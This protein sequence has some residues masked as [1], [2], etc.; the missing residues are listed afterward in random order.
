MAR[1][2]VIKDK[3][4]ARKG[5]YVDGDSVLAGD[6][7]VTGDVTFD[8]GI[9]VGA[10]IDVATIGPHAS[11]V[12][13]TQ[14]HSGVEYQVTGP[15][16]IGTSLSVGG[17]Y[18]GVPTG[19]TATRV[20]SEFSWVPD[21]SI[22]YNT[23][24]DQLEIVTDGQWK[25]VGVLNLLG[26]NDTPT[27]YT[28]AGGLYAQV[29][30]E[31][32]GLVFSA[33]EVDETERR[34]L[35]STATKKTRHV[36]C[37]GVT[38]QDT[39]LHVVSH[40]KLTDNVI[41][42]DDGS[43]INLWEYFE[44]G[45][46]SFVSSPDGSE[47][48]SSTGSAGTGYAR[49]KN[50]LSVEPGKSYYVTAESRN[51]ED[52]K[53]LVCDHPYAANSAA[54]YSGT[55]YAKVYYFDIPMLDE[56]G[57]TGGHAFDTTWTTGD[58]ENGQITGVFTAMTDK[59]FF[60]FRHGGISSSSYLDNIKVREIELPK[61]PLVGRQMGSAQT[62]T[63]G[64]VQITDGNWNVINTDTYTIS[65]WLKTPTDSGLQTIFSQQGDYDNLTNTRRPIYFR[66]DGSN[67]DFNGNGQTVTADITDNNWH[68]IAIT[69][70]D[71]DV[72][73]VYIDG[74]LIVDETGYQWASTSDGP[75]TG[76]RIGRQYG[77]YG[78]YFNGTLGDMLV[79]SRVLTQEEITAINN[80]HKDYPGDSLLMVNPL[81][82]REDAFDVGGNNIKLATE[83]YSD[84][85][86]TGTTPDF[87]DVLSTPFLDSDTAMRFDYAGTTH[88]ETT[89]DVTLDGDFTI[90]W[91]AYLES[92]EDN[93]VW[94][95]SFFAI[96]DG[97]KSDNT[98]VHV[99][100][101]Y[102]STDT[103]YH[104][105]GRT[106]AVVDGEKLQ[107]ATTP[108][109]IPLNQWNHYAIVREG[110]THRV[111]VNGVKIIEFDENVGSEP[112]SLTGTVNLGGT[113]LNT[114]MMDGWMQDFR[115]TTKAV[116]TQD[117][118]PNTSLTTVCGTIDESQDVVTSS[119]VVPERFTDMVDTPND[120][121]GQ[122]GL[123]PRVTDAEDGLTFST[124]DLE[125]QERILRVGKGVTSSETIVIHNKCA[126]LHVQASPLEDDDR[127]IRF[128]GSVGADL[129][130]NDP[131]NLADLGADDFTLESWI[132][133]YPGSNDWEVFQKR[134]YGPL[135]DGG[136]IFLNTNTGAAGQV[137]V[138]WA[139]DGTQ[140]AFT[141][142]LPGDFD[143]TTWH[144]YA[145][146]RSANNVKLYVD[147]VYVDGLTNLPTTLNP[148]GYNYI[149]LGSGFDGGQTIGADIQNWQLSSTVRY[150][151]NFTPPLRSVEPVIDNNTLAMLHAHGDIAT[152]DLVTERTGLTI[153][154]YEGGEDKIYYDLRNC[155]PC[156]I[157]NRVI[158]GTLTLDDTTPPRGAQQG[159]APKALFGNDRA[160]L[161]FDGTSQAITTV[162]NITIAEDADFTLEAWVYPLDFNSRGSYAT[163]LFNIGSESHFRLSL[164]P[165][166]EIK[167]RASQFGNAEPRSKTLLETDKW[168]HVAWVRESNVHTLYINGVA[169]QFVNAN[170]NDIANPTMNKQFTG[171]FRV[172]ALAGNIANGEFRGYMQDV[173]L[174]LDQA[175]YTSTTSAPT[176]LLEDCSVQATTEIVT[177][178]EEIIEMQIAEKFTDLTDTPTTYS[179]SEG[180]FAS[181]KPDG[182]GIEFTDITIDDT[183]ITITPPQDF[184]SI[185]H[186]QSDDV[187][188]ST[189]FVNLSPDGLPIT[190]PGLT[191]STDIPAINGFGSSVLFD[192]TQS[193]TEFQLLYADG[194][195]LPQDFTFEAWIHPRTLQQ[196]PSIQA[197]CPEFDQPFYTPTTF[198]RVIGAG[199]SYDPESGRTAAANTGIEYAFALYR[200]SS[201]PSHPLTL[202]TTYV[203]RDSDQ[204]YP[205]VQ[206]D[207]RDVWFHTSK[208]NLDQYIHMSSGN[209]KITKDDGNLFSS[210]ALT[211]YTGVVFDQPVIIGDDA[212]ELSNQVCIRLR[213][214]SELPS[215]TVSYGMVIVQTDEYDNDWY[216]LGSVSPN[217]KDF[218]ATPWT[219]ENQNEYLFTGTVRHGVMSLNTHAGTGSNT[220]YSNS[221]VISDPDVDT[222]AVLHPVGDR[223]RLSMLPGDTIK[224]AFVMSRSSN[225]GRNNSQQFNFIELI[226]DI[227]P[228]SGGI[229]DAPTNQTVFQ[230]KD[231][232]SAGSGGFGL[233]IDDGDLVID[234]PEQS[235][236]NAVTISDVISADTWHHLAWSR[237]GLTNII[238]VD[239]QPVHNFDEQQGDLSKDGKLY[240]GA[241]DTV[242]NPFDGY[243][244]DI[245]LVNDTAMYTQQFTPYTSKLVTCNKQST[246]TV[247]QQ[248]TDLTDT[249]TTYTGASGMYVRV[250]EDEDKL[251]FSTI[252]ID[253][254]SISVGTGSDPALPEFCSIFHVQSDSTNTSTAF[255]DLA[256][257]QQLSVK[258]LIEHSTDQT[259]NDLAT[260]VKFTNANNI[261]QVDTI[262]TVDNHTLSE[263]FTVETWMYITDKA[264]HT[265]T[266]ANLP[267]S[268]L[269]YNAAMDDTTQVIDWGDV[270]D[271]V[272]TYATMQDYIDTIDLDR[273]MAHVYSG[274]Y[275]F[276]A[277]GAVT[278][279]LETNDDPTTSNVYGGG[280]NSGNA[281]TLN[282]GSGGNYIDIQHCISTPEGITGIS[283]GSGGQ[284]NIIFEQEITVPEHGFDAAQLSILFQ[285]KVVM[286]DDVDTSIVLFQE[287][288]DPNRT[289][290][291]GS[292]WKFS[293]GVY[294]SS[295]NFTEKRLGHSVHF[296][297]HTSNFYHGSPSNLTGTYDVCDPS[298]AFASAPTL[299]L[300]PGAKFKLGYNGANLNVGNQMQ[301]HALRFTI[302]YEPYL[303]TS[304]TAN[305]RR[306]FTLGGL[307]AEVY[308]NGLILGT[309][310]N[311]RSVPTTIQENKWTHFAW[312][313]QNGDNKY[314]LD[315]TQ[316]NVSNPH[317][318]NGSVAGRFTLGSDGMKAGFAGYMQDA[319][320]LNN[321]AMYTDE[322]FTPPDQPL[323]TQNCEKLD[324]LTVP[325]EVV[326]YDSTDTD[327]GVQTIRSMTTTEY[328]TLTAAGQDDPNTLYMIRDGAP[329]GV[330]EA[331][332]FYDDVTINGALNVGGVT[333][334]GSKLNMQAHA[335]EQSLAYVKTITT[336]T[337]LDST[338]TGSVL[339]VDS[340]TDIDIGVPNSLPTGFNVD[341]IQINTG[342]ATLSAENVII[343]SIGSGLKTVQHGRSRLVSYAGDIYN[344]SGD[345][346][347]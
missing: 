94:A 103:W 324:T 114:A 268:E 186:V 227:I 279:Y 126:D 104:T 198:R 257:D 157:E 238:F 122:A 83:I 266:P 307:H 52:A 250:N 53:L 10:N 283:S 296:L 105:N 167:L 148:S 313:R 232:S 210:Q 271:T 264:Q 133:L 138:V 176:R 161:W 125:P 93:G 219:H 164:Q 304:A 29:N 192:N 334:M 220:S 4:R 236:S 128:T 72:Y 165:N 332:Q 42:E 95:P 345:I 68:H 282:I 136:R 309:P 48:F 178:T 237:S 39:A 298:N 144:H 73:K 234:I 131:D 341:I 251:L 286:S 273:S 242:N 15:I 140:Y 159:V 249:P 63:T 106:G 299:D 301:I 162:Q 46:N 7:H 191:H 41:F 261:S 316:V 310:E 158:G 175:I 214:D 216:Y 111:Y 143:S 190:T 74:V 21:G 153:H 333:T 80:D 65:F 287:S 78:E 276:A 323:I 212:S 40:G 12:D 172:G 244:Q 340:G 274:A 331:W 222:D 129:I 202:A 253:N 267:S 329:V 196:V 13:Q 258:G 317:D 163:T 85:W 141:Y 327:G 233:G 100:L 204:T 137:G 22:R 179:G 225:Y 30:T 275:A 113:W 123:I 306:I 86:V 5:L 168:T 344:F 177:N 142:N 297:Q 207:S 254:N 206:P 303:G 171:S 152:H 51:S 241:L 318:W 134:P 57:F 173:R 70:Q 243:M 92:Y 197:T 50:G 325:T 115:I 33:I 102:D 311:T 147:G 330:E 338:Y 135:Q 320:V 194:V 347:T 91:H 284:M 277:C 117:F 97:T 187:D 62:K 55:Q 69:V 270:D 300:S 76:V 8:T 174:F 89:Q 346:T 240:V 315:G 255:Q 151:N 90:E 326:R 11:I 121:A 99:R 292:Y 269:E 293:D 213:M 203:G 31:E 223:Q 3:F 37:D 336:D 230:I 305:N 247:L 145:V 166:G 262:Q 291:T 343:D 228:D 34:V 61:P 246:L 290:G 229:Q 150:T 170:G 19:D 14:I 193:S 27:T 180:L 259:I 201:S 116:Y 2:D 24:T 245:R 272:Q 231:D 182:T 265:V 308:S 209:G 124:I 146:T 339:V 20:N 6:L 335:V 189:T 16:T 278:Q 260:S 285:R 218:Q 47:Y 108:Y 81:T 183:S 32:D 188:A 98:S 96:H 312:T 132:R 26:L 263:D 195:S 200:A 110:M 184:C 84:D 211:T 127:C 60:G 88:V 239:G 139:K 28:G 221:S 43:N 302:T 235:I 215:D 295:R 71:A 23:D 87:N 59:V 281:L 160:A 38:T 319:R 75:N 181:V 77:G 199:S 36:S 226:G 149:R 169:D 112:V 25:S 205:N 322:T 119:I 101:A 321:Y 288:S 17:D 58:T 130:I 120:Y 79:Y 109:I 49:L 208:D 118:T 64:W 35:V 66:K 1:Q 252:E 342:A 156:E 155:D 56:A 107:R 9:E 294:A 289:Q 67:F 314:Y 337:V 44:S 217:N 18:L 154:D 224:I 328:D 54:F 45:G 82:D 256:L 280:S 185:V 248:F